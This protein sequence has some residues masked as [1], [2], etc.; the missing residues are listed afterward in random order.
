VSYLDAL[1]AFDYEGK[2]G[3]AL[4]PLDVIP[5]HEIVLKMKAAPKIMDNYSTHPD[6]GTLILPINSSVSPSS[7]IQ[8]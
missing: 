5:F 3:E 8:V 1:N 2:F 4:D 6:P 7:S